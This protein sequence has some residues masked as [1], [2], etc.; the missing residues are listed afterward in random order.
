MIRSTLRSASSLVMLLALVLSGATPLPANATAATGETWE[1]GRFGATTVY[2]PESAAS[3]VA[4]FISG[5]GGWNEGVV[6]MARALAAHGALVIGIDIRHYLAELASSHDRCVYPAA[7]FEDL[8]HAAEQHER[9]DDYLVPVVVG[10]SSGA[11]LV[12][13]L[14]AQAPP[15]TFAGGLSLG[16][17]P[18][19]ALHA[20]PCRG[21]GLEYNTRKNGTIVM[22]PSAAMPVPWIA[23]QGRLDQV[24]APAVTADYVA[25]TP[26]AQLVEL[27]NVGH[28]FS[29]SQDW[30][31]QYLASYS[32]LVTDRPAAAS[33]RS[34]AIGGLPVVEVPPV[35]TETPDPAHGASIVV[36]LTGDGGW[37]GIDRELAAKFVSR[38]VPVLGLNTL[39]Y[40]WHART[41]EQAT[42]DVSRIVQ[43]GLAKYRRT[44]VILVGYSF[45]A[46]VLPF[47]VNRLPADVRARVASLHLLGLSTRAD[48]EFHVAD[49][50]LHVAGSERGLPVVPEL[51]RLP[52]EIPKQCF[53]G[54][55]E[56]DDPCA[57]QT[58]EG[59]TQVGIGDGHH[60][61]GD[62]T[63]LVARILDLPAR[64]RGS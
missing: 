16:F 23:L 6:G 15:G 5:D 47:I 59:F 8:A 33:S 52:P 44:Q 64:G 19:L 14:L 28:G 34:S 22:R 26:Q 37:A 63:Q 53:F 29:K 43:Y 56:N 32:K 7:D 49:W 2:R 40:F 3:S 46:D 60:F 18:D 58:L 45:G 13:A 36:L 12:Y 41:P 38:G 17:S 27:P 48:F 42:G 9:L 4:L 57:T 30:M 62:T 51:A 39:K 55:G 1:H 50:W 31:P 21:S 25:R 20:P 11:S 10:Y 61:G 24:G 35:S 54:N